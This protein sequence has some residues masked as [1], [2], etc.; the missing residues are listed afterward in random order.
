MRDHEADKRPALGFSDV[1]TAVR[2]GFD[3]TFD[4][5][6]R[7]SASK[8]EW[9]SPATTQWRTSEFRNLFLASTEPASDPQRMRFRRGFA[10]RL[11]TK[12]IG[13]GSRKFTALIIL[14]GERRRRICAVCKFA[15]D[16][17]PPPIA[18]PLEKAIS[19]R[20]PSRTWTKF[21]TGAGQSFS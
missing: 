20:F 14:W 7:L 10:L 2:N 8:H 6:E 16:S 17:L 4:C 12:S 21:G 19:L 3:I 5:F 13:S 11:R 18:H 15:N 9:K 1:A